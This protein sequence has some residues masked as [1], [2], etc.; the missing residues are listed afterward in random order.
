MVARGVAHRGDDAVKHCGVRHTMMRLRAEEEFDVARAVAGA[1]RKHFVGHAVEV[2]SIDDRAVGAD[3]VVGFGQFAKLS[4]I[5]FPS[6]CGELSPDPEFQLVSFA[7]L[8]CTLHRTR[9]RMRSFFKE[10]RMK[11][12]E[13]TKLH[14]KSG[15]WQ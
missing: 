13:A 12:A 10:S 5:L 8:H 1:A 15:W 14:R 9:P 2:A 6:R 7:T 3:D 11:C 4:T